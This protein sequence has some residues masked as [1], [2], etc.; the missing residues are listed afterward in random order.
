MKPDLISQKIESLRTMTGIKSTRPDIPV[1]FAVQ[2]AYDL[3]EWCKSDREKLEKGGLDWSYA[4]DLPVRAGALR[5]LNTY[6]NTEK[7]TPYPALEEWKEAFSHARI[8]REEL[9]H[10]Y[11]YAF[12]GIPQLLRRVKELNRVSRK[13]E[14]IQSLCNLAE[15]GSKHRNKLENK[16]VD[17]TLIEKVREMGFRLPSLYSKSKPDNWEGRDGTELRNRAFYHLREAVNK[18]RKAGQKVFEDNPVA[19]SVYV[20]SFIKDKKQKEKNRKKKKK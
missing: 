20:S 11:K 17:L 16:G 18:V 2:E 13:D 1:P 12:H 19:Y 9:V 5:K 3:Y 7:N 6:W 14:F 15:L 4:E 8:L 10:S